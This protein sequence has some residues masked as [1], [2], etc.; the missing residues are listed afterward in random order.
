M[1]HE[2]QL[3]WWRPQAATDP[4]QR[5]RTGPPDGYAALPFWSL[6]AFTGVLLFSPQ[7]YVQGLSSL[8]PALLVMAI[9]ILSFVADRWSR[10][11]PLIQWNREV[12]LVAALLALAGFTVPLSVWPGGSL[13]VVTDYMKTVAVF[14]LLGHVVTTT[15]RLRQTAWLLTAMAVGLGLFAVYHFATGTMIDQGMNQDRV[16]GNEGALTKNPNDLALMINLLLPL[17]VGLFLSS[18]AAWQRTVLLFAIAMEALTVVLTYSRGGALTLGVIFLVYLWK[19]RRRPERTWMY[20]LVVAAIMALP[21]LPSSYFARMSTIT[22]MQADRTGSSQE[23]WTDMVIAGKTV[24]AN[25]LIGAGMG[26][27]SVA[28]REARGGGWL[29]VHNVYLEHALDLGVAGLLIFLALLTS[30]VGAVS[31]VQRSNVPRSLYALAQ[32]LEVSLIAYAVAA[33]FHPVS[34]HYYFYYIAGLAVAARSIAAA[35][36]RTTVET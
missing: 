3:E 27:N 34:Y 26:M 4:V 7:N 21:F 19:L 9:G 29:P 25:P 20:G 17:T 35:Q 1:A 14:I 22:D 31:Q 11:L 33:M 8:R 5:D 6:M 23:R 2:L 16:V 24:L 15:A 36:S 13:S 10:R 30:C 28:M 12:K 32:G 18:E